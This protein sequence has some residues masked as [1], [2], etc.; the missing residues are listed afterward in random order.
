M[1]SPCES[2]LERLAAGQK[3]GADEEAHVASCVDCAQLAKVPALLAASARE[4][5]PGPGFSARMQVGARG[6]LAARRRH[7][8]ALVSFASIA[9]AAAAVLAFTRPTH[10]VV[11]PGAIRTALDDE[12][13]PLPPPSTE[14][15]ITDQDLAAEL[16]RVANT[17]RTIRGEAHWNDIT[18]P[19]EPYRALLSKHGV[20][21]ASR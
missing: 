12:H 15:P 19:L 7:R 9:V 11:Q 17:D 2:I 6:R 14:T 8:V 1:M 13:L 21:G 16:V 4:P 18:R 3:L 10:H 20:Q 5:D